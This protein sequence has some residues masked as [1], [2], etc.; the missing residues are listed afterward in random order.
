M[1]GLQTDWYG[2]TNAWSRGFPVLDS[3]S[4]SRISTLLLDDFLCA[5]S[6]L[7]PLIFNCRILLARNWDV[8]VKHIFREANFIDDGL[9]EESQMELYMCFHF[10]YSIFI[11]SRR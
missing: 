4:D 7:L 5:S 9:A 1:E 3:E 8:Q 2:F 10:V 6:W 11:F